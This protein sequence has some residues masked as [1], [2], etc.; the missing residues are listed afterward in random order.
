MKNKLSILTFTLLIG[1]LSGCEKYL[2][3]PS[4][5]TLTEEV[6]F[7][8]YKTFQGFIEPC[9]SLISD[10]N[11][12]DLAI[13]NNIGTESVSNLGASP[14]TASLNQNY[15]SLVNNGSRSIWIGFES[16]ISTPMDAQKKG[17]YHWWPYGSRIANI[18]LRNLKYLKDAKPGEKEIL[19]GQA[20]FFRAYYNFEVA[21]AFGSIPYLDKVYEDGDEARLPRYWTDSISGKKDFQAVAEKAARD[22]Q[23]A[24]ELLPL[25][26]DDPNVGRITKGAALALKSKVLLYAGS[27][28]F[29]ESSVKGKSA[30]T[31]DQTGYNKDYLKRA[32]EAAAEVIKLGKYSLPVWGST[33][34][35]YA[36]DG[37]R[38]TF[39]TIDGK[40]P[41]TNETI[42]Q[43]W[44]NNSSS[45][46]F[47]F[48]DR[49]CR[50][51]VG[52]GLLAVG[53]AG[54]LESPLLR[55]MDKFEMK[56]GTQYKPG[57]KIDGGYDDDL[58]KFNNQRDPRFQYNYRTHGEKI[59]AHTT[60]F[61]KKGT[62]YSADARGPFLM[63]KFWY[64][65]VDNINQQW[66]QFTYRDPSI[67]YA[68]V[69]LWYAEAVFESTGNPD[70]SIG[71][72]LTARQAVNMIRNRALM[73]DYN[74]ANYSVARTTHGELSSD[75][76]F[77]LAYRNERC[78]ELAY[79]GHYWF[80]LR[81]WKRS[82]SLEKQVW[83]LDFNKD[84]TSVTRTV[85]QPF[86]FEMR[87]YW[88][89]FPTTHTQIFEGF[90]Q[91]PGW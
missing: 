79:E 69:L 4:D 65:L 90:P 71:V 21:R 27:P 35:D 9:Y 75:N 20:L 58:D 70:A 64:P 31:S 15:F 89:P 13:T 82:Y 18:S 16:G 28:L 62:V 61:D 44:N 50:I 30:V 55:Y 48:R 10:N 41:F 80:D 68:D 49:I 5:A 29:E 47:I 19:E 87:N 11:C 78:V 45:G 72:P 60:Y 38:R 86:L 23:R 88:L 22:L 12:Q 73:P 39:A 42:F 34:G 8:S 7:S 53:N 51:Y 25:E 63:T 24:S 54:H 81:R 91:N 84:Y 17:L 59:G 85:L 14:V 57:N 37:Y 56:D 6:I 40:V 26:W 74:P 66:G 2:S 67:R 76:Q 43:R 33:T 1:I 36:G 77:R 46:Q 3:I 83:I 52:Q 32:A